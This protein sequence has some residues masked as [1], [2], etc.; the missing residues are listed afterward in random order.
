LAKQQKTLRLSETAI[1]MVQEV[2]DN[3]DNDYGSWTDALEYM[4]RN[5]HA[6]HSIPFDDRDKLRV[7]CKNGSYS[8]LYDSNER[9]MIN[10]F[11]V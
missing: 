1:K 8:E 10:I 7:S 5:S 6:V 11:W 2:F 9:K 3:K 4:I